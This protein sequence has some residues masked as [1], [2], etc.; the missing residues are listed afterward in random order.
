[1]R[2]LIAVKL[3]VLHPQTWA[4]D[5][6]DEAL[7]PPRDASVFLCGMWSLWMGRNKCRHGEARLMIC[8]TSTTHKEYIEVWSRTATTGR[9]QFLVSSSAM[10]MLLSLKK[11][12]LERQGQF[13]VT[14]METSVGEQQSGMIIVEIL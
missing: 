12:V 6:I 1:M 9:D 14:M 4:H 3:S 7:F 10:W 5:L 11:I 2:R 8:G 13:S